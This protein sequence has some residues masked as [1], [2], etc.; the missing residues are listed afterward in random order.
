MRL[1]MDTRSEKLQLSPLRKSQFCGIHSKKPVALARENDDY[2][3]SS[4]ANV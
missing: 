3:A 4:D 1:R 2:E